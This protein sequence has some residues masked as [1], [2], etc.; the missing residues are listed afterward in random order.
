MIEKHL[1]IQI[2]TESVEIKFLFFIDGTLDGI[3]II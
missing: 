1:P 3:I 2:N